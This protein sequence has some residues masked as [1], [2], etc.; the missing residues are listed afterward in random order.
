MF[1]VPKFTRIFF[2]TLLSFSTSLVFASPFEIGKKWPVFWRQFKSQPKEEYKKYITVKFTNSLKEAC[3]QNEDA[4]YNYN[5]ASLDLNLF[6]SEMKSKIY[7]YSSNK[8]YKKEYKR[9]MSPHFERYEIARIRE[10]TTAVEILRQAGFGDWKKYSRWNSK[11]VGDLW[12]E[13]VVPMSYEESTDF[14][15][16]HPYITKANNTARKECKIYGY[17]VK[18]KEI[19]SDELDY[20]KFK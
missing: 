3:K 6:E 12:R 10:M 2:L 16:N 7:N 5:L 15:I 14:I 4:W 18:Y 8:E 19:D 13:K 9:I 1:Q 20:C 17:E 11:G